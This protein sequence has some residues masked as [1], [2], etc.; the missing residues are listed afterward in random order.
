MKRKYI[1]KIAKL[2]DSLIINTLLKLIYKI[3][4]FFVWNFWNLT[5]KVNKLFSYL[6]KKTIFQFLLKN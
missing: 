2:I 1:K 6:I 5:K 4:Y 3:K